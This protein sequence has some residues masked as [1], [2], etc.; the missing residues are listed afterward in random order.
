MIRFCIV[1]LLFMFNMGLAHAGV[2]KK[3]QRATEARQT[4]TLTRMLS[5]DKSVVRQRAAAGL[6]KCPWKDVREMSVE[7]LLTCLENASERD[8]VRA[9][10]GKTLAFVG[11][12]RAVSGIIG[13]ISDARGDARFSLVEALASFRTPEAKATLNELKSDIDPFISSAARG[14]KP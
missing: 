11:E 10:C 12:K 14:T 1:G 5:H 7:P 2:F 6:L 4:Q 8:F 13:A 3:L 9:A